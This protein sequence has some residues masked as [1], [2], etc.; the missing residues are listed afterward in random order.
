MLPEHNADAVRNYFLEPTREKFK[1]SGEE[2]GEE[3]ALD[4]LEKMQVLLFDKGAVEGSAMKKFLGDDHDKKFRF[5]CG[6][7][8]LDGNILLF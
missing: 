7:H 3:K 2:I 6:N 8:D 1:N 5:G 4:I